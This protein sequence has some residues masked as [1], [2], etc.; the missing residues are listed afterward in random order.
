MLFPLTSTTG[1]I[2]AAVAA[3]CR[4]LVSKIRSSP[5]QRLA[6]SRSGIPPSAMTVSY[7]AARNHRPRPC[8]IWSHKNRGTNEVLSLLMPRVYSTVSLRSG[9][10]RAHWGDRHSGE[11][12][13]GVGGP[14]DE[15]KFGE[16]SGSSFRLEGLG[17]LMVD[18]HPKPGPGKEPRFMCDEM[19]HG[20][21]RWLRAAGYDTVFAHGD[22]P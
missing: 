19:M 12:S 17:E 20:L 7:P 16:P 10:L 21:G 11:F 9:S 3:R 6:S 1:A 8:S 15:E 4:S 5:A 22:L 14:N 2:P 18:D 13:G